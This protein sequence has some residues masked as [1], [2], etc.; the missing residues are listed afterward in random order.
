M[1][2]ELDETDL[3]LI[4]ELESDASI[5]KKKLARKLNI[6]LTTIHNRIRKMEIT[7]VIR[8]YRAAI[9]KKK[10]GKGVAAFV[11]I[12][13]SYVSPDFS[14]QEIGK[15]LA[16]MPEV[17]EVAI[18]TGGTDLQ[19]KV[20]VNSTDELND[21]ITRK[22]RAIKGIDKT[23]TRVILQEIGKNHQRNIK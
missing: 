8:G 23:N 6:P 22:L 15:R 19:L 13:V 14:Q 10:I 12:T 9:D 4:S 5:T 2:F 18:V 16:A 7:G 11:D 3:R 1:K 21:F 20:Y 17:D